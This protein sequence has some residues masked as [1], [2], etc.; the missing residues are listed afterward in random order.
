MSTS[1]KICNVGSSKSNSD[2]VCVLNDR[3]KNMSTA[4]KDDKMST[5][6]NC[7]K[8]G[9]NNICNKC[10]M[11]KY[12]NATCKKK[13]RHKHKKQC[14]EHVKL[15]AE[16]HNEE[17]RRIAELHDE[18]LFKQPPKLEDCL[19]CFLR[20]PTLTSG[21]RYMACC[22]KTICS[23]CC[24]APLYDH[25]GNEVDNNKCP[26]CRVVAPKSDK[27]LNSV[28]IKRSEAGDVPTLLST[29]VRHMYSYPQFL[30]RIYL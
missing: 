15:A 27:E 17:L 1:D 29:A 12:C 28:L 18:K 19:I 24:H 4:D 2:D 7:N 5:C 9:A 13:H 30:C 11:V 20:L 10:K 26:F 21:T 25:Q 14:E 23:G 3:L 8:K 16:K 6:A 22:G